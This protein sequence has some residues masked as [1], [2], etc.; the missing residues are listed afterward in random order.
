VSE[1]QN[2]VGAPQGV[3]GAI[4][5]ASVPPL[6]DVLCELAY[7]WIAANLPFSTAIDLAPRTRAAERTLGAR[8]TVIAAEVPREGTTGDLPERSADLVVW[9]ELTPARPLTS[10]LREAA[11]LCRSDG[12]VA[13]VLP[14]ADAET[15]AEAAE[16]N[17]VARLGLRPLIGASIDDMFDPAGLEL[18]GTAPY[19]LLVL[20]SPRSSGNGAPTEHAGFPP[21]IVRG[22]DR[23]LRVELAAMHALQRMQED[24]R[25]QLQERAARSERDAESERERAA[26]L[27]R[28]LA[29]AEERE[30]ELRTGLAAGEALAEQARTA[31]R[32]SAALRA[33][34]EA[35]KGWLDEIQRSLSWRITHPLRRGK[36][37]I[38]R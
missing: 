2:L 10:A 8:G 32:E 16:R 20:R 19:Q 35:H 17:E 34:L 25:S 4:H 26:D 36:R 30:A 3:P 15:A 12:T 28:R 33:E 6:L 1:P 9:M 5:A 31:A 21:V 22:G 27:E 24:E 29:A 37:A 7:E 18:G 13:C 23:A 14:T 11:R 38:R